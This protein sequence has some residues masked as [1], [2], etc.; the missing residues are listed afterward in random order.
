MGKGNPGPGNYNLEYRNKQGISILPRRKLFYE[1]NNLCAPAP[2][3]YDVDN[4]K[5]KNCF[6]KIGNELRLRDTTDK[7]VPGPGMY[8][9]KFHNLEKNHQ[10]RSVF[11][12]SFRKQI[13]SATGEVPGPGNY[14][15]E[16]KEAEGPKFSMTGKSQDNKAK[17]DAKCPG[18]NH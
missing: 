13:I 17:K 10:P 8:D 18:P 6:V 5:I 2:G 15:M 7:D 1:E 14:D 9:S 12:T 11:G 3:T 4:A 16:K